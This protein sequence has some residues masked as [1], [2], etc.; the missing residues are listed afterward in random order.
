MD[1]LK[2]ERITKRSKAIV[3]TR[4]SLAF[5]RLLKITIILFFI[6]GVAILFIPWQQTAVGKGRVIAFLPTERVQAITTHIAGRIQKWHVTEGSFV[7]EGDLLAEIIDNDPEILNR[8]RSEEQAALKRLQ[9]L[10]TQVVAN[11]NN[12]KRQK[13]LFQEGIVS[14]RQ[15]ELAEIE[16]AQSI[17]QKAA[18]QVELNRIQVR[19]SQQN[20]QRLTSPISGTIQ[21]IIYG[22]N[23][24]FLKA[25]EIIA[26]IAPETK[27]RVVELWVSGRDLPFIKLGQTVRIQFDGWPIFQIS[28]LPELSVGTFKGFVQLIDPSDDGKGYFRVIVARQESDIWPSPRL[29]RQGV[30]AQGWIAMNRVPLWFEIWRTVL[31]LPPMPVPVTEDQ[32]HK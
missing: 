3:L 23:T 14:Q 29:L 4:H 31:S 30:K 18:A 13:S 27:N 8:L 5:E 16:L 25:G 15:V 2:I 11:E 26:Y 21:K 28:G 1:I 22:E 24:Q 32:I 19:L 10:E 9:V 12:L 7:E 20:M 6:F 17:S